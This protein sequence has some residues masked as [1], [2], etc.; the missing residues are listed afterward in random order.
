MSSLAINDENFKSE[1]DVVK[2][3]FRQRI[4]AN[5]YGEFSLAIDQKSFGTHP[6]KTADDWQYC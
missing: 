3:E 2:E 5:P 1:R 6:Y 4:A